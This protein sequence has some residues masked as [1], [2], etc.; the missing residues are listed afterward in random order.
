MRKVILLKNH[1]LNKKYNK[2][3]KNNF[4]FYLLKIINNAY[5]KQWRNRGH[6]CANIEAI[7]TNSTTN[8]KLNCKLQNI[9]N[10]LK[11]I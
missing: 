9:K 6:N 10:Y 11:V 5:R 1:N 4:S 3:F 2:N 7:F 8:E